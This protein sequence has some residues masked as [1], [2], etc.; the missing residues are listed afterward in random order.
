[1]I[2]IFISFNEIVSQLLIPSDSLVNFTKRKCIHNNSL[3]LLNIDE[4]IKKYQNTHD[5]NFIYSKLKRNYE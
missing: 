2:Q 1:M 4:A 5:L 3:I